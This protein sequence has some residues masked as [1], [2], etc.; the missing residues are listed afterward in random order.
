MSTFIRTTKGNEIIYSVTVSKELWDK[1]KKH[2]Q[3]KVAKNTEIKGFRKGH[4]P[5]KIANEH[6]N[7]NDVFNEAIQLAGQHYHKILME[8]QEF[9]KEKIVNNSL[10]ID[11]APSSIDAIPKILFIC[12][13]FPDVTIGDYRKINFTFHEQKL[14]DDMVNAQI[15]YLIKNDTML[16]AKEPP[17]VAMGDMAI[18]DFLGKIDNKEFPGGQASDYELEIG[19]NQFIPGFEQQLVGLKKGDKKTI[20]VTFPNDYHH[21]DYKGKAATFDI[22][23]KDVKTMNLPTLDEEYIAKLK[24]PNVKTKDELYAHIRSQLSQRIEETNREQYINQIVDFLIKHS[25]LS[26]T[27]PSLLKTERDLFLKDIEQK[28]QEAKMSVEDFWKQRIGV[29]DK[30]KQEEFIQTQSYHTLL[31]SCVLEKIIADEKIT[32]AE[33]DIDTHLEEMANMYKMKV[34]DLKKIFNNNFAKLNDFILN[35]KVFDFIIAINKK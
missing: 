28:A 10:R 11:V 16:I 26:Y 25:K 4:A 13:K 5:T 30:L 31:M 6:V 18:I 20:S 1:F 17:I 33:K 35:K 34:E 19:S 9:L 29:T 27:P 24:L 7:P 21:D 2:A 32:V 15:K 14:N 8:D 23:I 3:D 12:D 22:E